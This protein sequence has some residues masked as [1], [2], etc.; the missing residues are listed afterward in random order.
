LQD[1]RIN[2]EMKDRKA[3]PETDVKKGKFVSKALP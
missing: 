3:K 2:G 1:Y